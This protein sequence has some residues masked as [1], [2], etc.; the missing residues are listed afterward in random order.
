MRKN[1][2]ILFLQFWAIFLVVLG[3]AFVDLEKRYFFKDLLLNFRM[4]LFFTIS[5]FL[6]MLKIDRHC[7]DP[8]NFIKKKAQHLLLPYLFITILSYGI[9]SQLTK[10]SVRPMTV[11]IADFFHSLI[12]PWDNPNIYMWFLPTLFIL[13]VVYALIAQIYKF[14]NPILNVAILAVL[15]VLSVKFHLVDVRFVPATFLNYTGCLHYLVYF[16]IGMMFCYV[17]EKVPSFVFSQLCMSIICV[18]SLGYLVVIVGAELPMDKTLYALF[19]ITFSW[20][21]AVVMKT[22]INKLI[23]T[24][25][26][27]SYQIYLLSWFVHQ[28]VIIVC[29]KM[30]HINEYICFFLGVVLALGIPIFISILVK[31]YISSS[32]IRMLIDL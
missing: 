26:L 27:Y 32:K 28:A 13:F 15:L 21:L 31:K 11:S 1:R 7:Q 30:L 16:Y 23:E 3:H 12:Y 10:Y 6:F 29:W 24:I 20:S 22:H 8:I 5:G 17:K 9:K 18:L 2:V 14:R 25:R 19:G 4:P